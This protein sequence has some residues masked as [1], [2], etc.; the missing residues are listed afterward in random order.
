[1]WC[2]QMCILKAKV[3][4]NNNFISGSIQRLIFTLTLFYGTIITSCKYKYIFPKPFYLEFYVVECLWTNWFSPFLFLTKLGL[5]HLTHFAYELIHNRP[6]HYIFDVL[7][8]WIKILSLLYILMQF[9][10]WWNSDKT[11]QEPRT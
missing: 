6:A 4:E 2:I 10:G 11:I 1:M 3:I 9:L 8:V 7:V 5:S